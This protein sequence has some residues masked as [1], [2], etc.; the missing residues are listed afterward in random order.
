MRL[1]WK[2]Q[3]QTQIEIKCLKQKNTLGVISRRLTAGGKQISEF[4]S[5]LTDIIENIM[6]RSSHWIRSCKCD[7]SVKHEGFFAEVRLSWDM[8]GYMELA[9]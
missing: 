1:L 7:D 8:K 6:Y 9:R 2:I 3:K 5:R 4:S